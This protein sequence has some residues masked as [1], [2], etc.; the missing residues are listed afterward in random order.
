[1]AFLTK[2]SDFVEFQKIA[3]CAITLTYSEIFENTEDNIPSYA[4]HCFKILHAIVTQNV[5]PCENINKQEVTEHI[6]DCDALNTEIEEEVQNKSD[7]DMWL[8]IFSTKCVA[9]AKDETNK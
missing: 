6:I 2:V 8:E 9:M 4:E 5:V 7:I 3:K 1:M